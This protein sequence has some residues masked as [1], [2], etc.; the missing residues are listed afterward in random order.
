MER[1]SARSLT[2]VCFNGRKLK[3][4]RPIERLRV[5]RE[6]KS[7]YPAFVLCI[8]TDAGDT[9][10]C[11]KFLVQRASLLAHFAQRVSDVFD[12]AY[13][14][15]WLAFEGRSFYGH[16]SVGDIF[17]LVHADDQILYGLVMLHV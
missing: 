17:D 14:S 1:S 2:S 15:F 10:K 5:S 7:L 11:T 13:P 6:Q 9:G 8:V 12:R 3:A 4:Q 16:C